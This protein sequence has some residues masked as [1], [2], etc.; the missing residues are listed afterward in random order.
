MMRIEYMSEISNF[1][2][3]TVAGMIPDI[4]GPDTPEAVHHALLI[5]CTASKSR[6]RHVPERRLN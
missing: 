1:G 6:G 2:D 5:N 4:S 3:E